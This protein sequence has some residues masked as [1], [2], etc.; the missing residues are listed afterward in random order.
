MYSER[1]KDPRWQKK[2]LQIMERDGFTCRLCSDTETTLNVH[3]LFYEKGADPWDYPDLSLLTV[4]EPCHEELH[5]YRFGESLLEALIA[6][7]ANLH[8]LYGLLF[9]VQSRFIDGPFNDGPL[10]QEQW[11]EVIDA[12]IAVLKRSPTKRAVS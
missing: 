12:L 5:I 8:V 6:G 11:E 9:A 1:L 4:C 10:S 2:R 7:G 3:H